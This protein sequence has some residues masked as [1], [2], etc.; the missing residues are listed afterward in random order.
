M[1][2]ADLSTPVQLDAYTESYPRR[3]EPR[4]DNNESTSSQAM[5]E[6]TAGPSVEAIFSPDSKQLG[7][8]S[9]L[10][11]SSTLIVTHST[12]LP[13]ALTLMGPLTVQP[14]APYP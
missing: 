9:D 5:L 1:S 8:P 7:G 14:R 2:S 13:W 12:L 6:F 4:Q 3:I 11:V 10:L